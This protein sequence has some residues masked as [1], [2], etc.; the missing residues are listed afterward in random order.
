MAVQDIIFE[1]QIKFDRSK[2]SLDELDR[3]LK[4]VTK[5]IKTADKNTDDYRKAQIRLKEINKQLSGSFDQ[6]GK[7]VNNLS[8]KLKTSGAALAGISALALGAGVGF[9]SAFNTIKEFDQALADLS[10]ITGATGEDLK[11]YEEQAKKIG[12]TTSLS[13]KQAADA[14]I[15]IGSAAPKLL[16]NKEALAAVT[17]QAVILAEAAG[18]ELPQAADALTGAMAQ[19]KLP[20]DDAV[21]IIDQLANGS[22]F[23]AAAVP[24]LVDTLK[25]AGT[26][27]NIAGVKLDEFVTATE[28][29]A[30]SQIKGAEAGTKLKGIFTQLSKAEVL[31]KEATDRLKA[32]G[33]D[34]S[35]L[36][37]QSVSLRD[38]LKALEPVKDDFATL[39]LAFNEGAGALSNLINAGDGFDELKVKIN[40]LGTAEEQQAIRI[41]TIQ[42]ALNRLSSSYEGFIL[43]AS[44]SSGVLRIAID[45]LATNFRT[46]AKFIGLT[47]LAVVSFKLAV[48]ASDFAVKAYRLTVSALA[49]AK[50]F[51]RGG[52]RAAKIEM[53]AFN[54]ATKANIIGAI[55]SLLFTAVAAF[56]AFKKGAKEAASAQRELNDAQKEA[57]GSKERVNNLL[58]EASVAE[59]LSN[60]QI[61]SLKGRIEQEIALLKDKQTRVIS[62]NEQTAK[63][64]SKIDEARLKEIEALEERKSNITSAS[65]KEKLSRLIA[66]LKSQ[67]SIQEQILDEQ[68]GFQKK[69]IENL[70]QSLEE[71]DKNLKLKK[72]PSGGGLTDEE[73]KAALN[74]RLAEIAE[75]ERLDSAIA[76]LDN[77][78]EAELLE[79]KVNANLERKKAIEAFRLTE[80]DIYK[81]I[82]NDLL[83]QDK[84]SA[85]IILDE[86]E[87]T[88]NEKERIALKEAKINGDKE[89]EILIQTLF[90][91]ESRKLLLEKNN[92]TETDE[93]KKL[94]ADILL[95]EKQITAQSKEERLKAN[96]DKLDEEQRHQDAISDIDKDSELKR[97]NQT[98]DI[99]KRR[100]K[101][102]KQ[103]HGDQEIEVIKQ[104][105]IIQEL[106]KKRT[107]LI[108]SENEERKEAAKALAR[109]IIASSNDILQSELDKNSKQ[110]ESQQTR[111][112]KARELAEKGNADILEQE[113]KRLEEL[114][115]KRENFARAQQAIA[116]IE[117]V[118]NSLIAVS[119][120]AAEGGPAA[121]FTIA[122]TLIAFAAGIVQARQTA[123]NA[124]SFFVGGEYD[125]S[126]GRATYSNRTG[127]TGEGS[128]TS[129][130]TDLGKKPYTYHKREFISNGKAVSVGRN[131]MWLE[132]LNK[133]HF[134]MDHVF[135]TAKRVHSYEIKHKIQGNN[136]TRSDQDFRELKEEMSLLRKEIRDKPVSNLSVTERGIIETI[137]TSNF[138]RTRIKR[139]GG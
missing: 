121:P 88:L 34:V 118:A 19:F 84:E 25:G 6:Q 35:L 57:L 39:S 80:L 106:E 126:T 23:G 75:K 91:A 117:I 77:K 62:I 33:V 78:S 41:N 68:T 128:F 14:F 1:A 72:E 11:F 115:K 15:V 76:K 96:E 108:I 130:S 111:V 45:F 127:F 87:N 90:F 74:K 82:N 4:E 97:L 71:A 63:D 129:T 9:K 52:I 18:I 110:I 67:K 50:A 36:G 133:E 10:A 81:K 47:A 94:K 119:K 38:K 85:K 61:S 5:T 112:E 136:S 101:L 22:K 103:S 95:L 124:A 137:E 46:I 49:T 37:D 73:K 56:I 42:G 131:K 3:E 86:R 139:I 134:N 70:I 66:G 114:K 102:L 31:P 64:A 135:E 24:E 13:A 44:N 7:S 69:E 93:Y 16:E 54:A 58:A 99:E 122:A 123:Q 65:E 27:A 55:V 120:A 28:I 116:Q 89:S 21:K 100:L 2:S 26:E 113:E 8:T 30:E 60:Q 17:E 59:K 105:N 125:Y 29:L 83:I 79:I 109:Q 48:K 132:K 40:T 32:A 98:I 12:E 138:K 53:L 51:L 92:K 104:N 20:A 107:D 43:K